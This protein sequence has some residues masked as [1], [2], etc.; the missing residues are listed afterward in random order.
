MKRGG[1]KIFLPLRWNEGFEDESVYLRLE[2]SA[3]TVQEN[4]RLTSPNSLHSVP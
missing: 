3:N 4:L 1:S 2:S